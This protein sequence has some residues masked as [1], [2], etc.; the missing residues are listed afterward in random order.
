MS[1]LYLSGLTMAASL[2]IAGFANA[3]KQVQAQSCTPLAAVGA[4]TSEV[5]KVVSPPGTGITEDNWHTD[6][7]VPEGSSYSFY[8]VV[9]TPMNGGDYDIA[10]NLKYPNDSV[11]RAYS[12]GAYPLTEGSPLTID[13]E[14]RLTTDPYQVNVQVGGVPALGNRY[15]VA[16]YGCV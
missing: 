13:A 3:P 1:K 16:A 6:F 2:A 7:T 15:T 5:E 12:V 4:S 11:D 9:V 8:T 10:L 14:P